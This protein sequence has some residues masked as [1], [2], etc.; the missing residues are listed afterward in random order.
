MEKKKKNCQITQ[1]ATPAGLIR[2]KYQSLV[3]DLKRN[4]RNMKGTSAR[5]ISGKFAAV[6]KI[7]RKDWKNWKFN[8]MMETI[9]TISF[10]KLATIRK[11]EHGNLLLH[12]RRE[13]L[14]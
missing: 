12:D 1:S 10:W 7:L 5:I 2:D 8:Q 9:P 13:V 14:V 3:R 6:L 4:K 11:K